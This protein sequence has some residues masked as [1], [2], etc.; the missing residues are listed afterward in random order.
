MNLNDFK[1]ADF[2]LTRAETGG[3]TGGF[4]YILCFAGSG[5]TETPFYVGQ[6]DRF[7]GRMN[8][9]RL[10]SFSACTDFCVGE[11]TRYLTGARNFR[12]I[13]RYRT[14]I[15]PRTEEKR[16]IRDLL[17][18]GVRLL[19]CLPRYDYLTAGEAEERDAIH[20]FCDLLAKDV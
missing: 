15:S 7:H 5:I 3:I 8:D 4:V 12:V 18:S 6:T 9:Y 10:A 1:A 13:V 19:N 17:I 14:S 2:P 20:R 16:I 11:A